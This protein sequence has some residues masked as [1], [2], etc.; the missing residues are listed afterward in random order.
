MSFIN[1]SNSQNKL[2]GSY[3]DLKI[4]DK[5]SSKNTLLELKNG[6][7]IFDSKNFLIEINS[8]FSKKWFSFVVFSNFLLF[9][10]TTETRRKEPINRNVRIMNHAFSLFF[11]KN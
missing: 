7:L 9:L 1:I 4:L 5:I 2:E 11:F 3:T 8:L 10:K 6:E